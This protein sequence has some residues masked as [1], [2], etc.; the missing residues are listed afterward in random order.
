[1][2]TPL[3]SGKEAINPAATYP[4]RTAIDDPNGQYGQ[5][6]RPNHYK[7][8]TMS[9]KLTSNQP[10]MRSERLPEPN[11]Q[12]IHHTN[13]FAGNPATACQTPTSLGINLLNTQSYDYVCIN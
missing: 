5:I 2:E 13:E 12:G 8:K 4:N 6:G 10:A 1:M 11:P 9:N 3:I 7:S